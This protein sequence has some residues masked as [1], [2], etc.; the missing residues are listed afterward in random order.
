MAISGII[1]GNITL[2]IFVLSGAIYL[3]LCLRQVLSFRELCSVADSEFLPALSIV[4]PLCGDEPRLYECL[5][6]FCDQDY[7][8]YQVVFGVRDSND[9]AVAVVARLKAEFPQ[10]DIALVCDARIHGANLKISNVMNIMPACRHDFLLVSDSDV[11]V[12]QDC[13]RAVVAAMAEPKV[14]AVS[15]IYKGAPTQG[16]VSVL[17][18]LNINTWIVPSVLLDRALNGIDACLGPVLLLRRTALGDIGGFPA[19]ANYLAEDHEIGEM[20][21]RAGWDVRLSAYTVDTMVNEVGLGALFRHEVRWAHTV[22]SVRPS[23][24]FLSL[25]TCSLPLLLVLLAMTPT[26]WGGGLVG[27]Y[28]VLR[29][30]LDRAVSARFTLTRRTSMWLAPIRECL[31]FAVW[32]YSTFSRAVVWRGQPFKLLSGGRLVPL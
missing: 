32:L 3:S 29:L 28:L 19:V 31:C 25:V 30:W 6:S 10:R 8:D 1:I 9:P 26:W 24:H 12:G 13:L 7:P 23:D 27:G 20:L 21:N 16:W 11:E 18:A 4:K 17:G 2:V 5:R 14:G 22:R 15:C